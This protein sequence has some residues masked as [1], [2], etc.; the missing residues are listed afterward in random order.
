MPWKR[1]QFEAGHSLEEGADAALPLLFVA[2][3]C[4]DGCNHGSMIYTP[5][6]VLDGGGDLF[7][8][9]LQATVFLALAV[10]LRFWLG[11]LADRRGTKP[12]MAL[13]LAAAYAVADSASG[14]VRHVRCGACRPLRAGGGHGGVLPLR[15]FGRQRGGRPAKFGTDAR[16]LSTGFLGGSHGI[17]GCS[18]P[19]RAVDRLCGDIH[20]DGHRRCLG[21][22]LRSGGPGAG[23]VAKGYGTRRGGRRPKESRLAFAVAPDPSCS[24]ATGRECARRD[25]RGRL[26]A[27]GSS[28]TSQRPLWKRRHRRLTPVCLWRWWEWGVW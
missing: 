26:Q 24:S 13:G 15:P 17:G 25:L 7:A 9:G 6:L 12:L 20:C 11:P 10:A 21:A 3:F 2:G 23:A 8:V 1:M 18:V 22:S 16:S 27:T 19:A 4:A 28:R 5:L 14:A